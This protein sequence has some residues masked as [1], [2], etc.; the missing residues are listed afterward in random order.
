L[1]AAGLLA[2]SAL[3]SGLW[4]WRNGAPA[5]NGKKRQDPLA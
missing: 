1:L 4:A 5:G 3:G 2:L